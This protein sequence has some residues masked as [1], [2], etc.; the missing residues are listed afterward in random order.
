LF[1]VWGLSV[2]NSNW[3]GFGSGIKRKGISLDPEGGRDTKQFKTAPGG[4]NQTIRRVWA[5]N[6]GK[7]PKRGLVF[8]TNFWPEGEG[9]KKKE[10]TSCGG[11]G[12]W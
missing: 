10:D 8:R 5:R 4:G 11:R 2:Q 9:Q 6:A 3:G 12:N 7:T 1:Q